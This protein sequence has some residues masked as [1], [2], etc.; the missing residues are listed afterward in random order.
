VYITLYCINLIY[1]TRMNEYLIIMN[2]RDFS[3]M[4][5]TRGF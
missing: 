3:I 4:V 2:N 1:N 5:I